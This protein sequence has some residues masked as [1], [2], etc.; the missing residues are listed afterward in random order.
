[1]VN[2]PPIA[3]KPAPIITEPP[4]IVEPS[5]TP[6]SLALP[7]PPERS[8]T[9]SWPVVDDPVVTCPEGTIPSYGGQECIPITVPRK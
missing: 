8:I 4:T 6:P 9:S 5:Y 3:V 7:E 2:K 1:M